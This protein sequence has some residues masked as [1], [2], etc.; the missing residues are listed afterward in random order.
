M[1]ESKCNDDDDDN[2]DDDNNNDDDD[3][4]EWSFICFSITAMVML[5][6][7]VIPL[8]FN[9][10]AVHIIASAHNNS[11]S[12]ESIGIVHSAIIF[13]RGNV[14]INQREQYE[15]GRTHKQYTSF[16]DIN[17]GEYNDKDSDDDEDDDNNNNKDD[18]D[19]DDNDDDDDDDDDDDA[20]TD[21][22]IEDNNKDDDDEEEDNG[23]T[24]IIAIPNAG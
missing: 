15:Y 13:P 1:I 16:Q 20:E 3:D 10:I 18:D 23:A 11:W 14:T 6:H 2:G 4:G 17:D 8:D 7:D 22:V 12:V 9:I 5:L 21:D 19:D 24:S